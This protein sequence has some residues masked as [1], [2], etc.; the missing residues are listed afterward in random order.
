[1]PDPYRRGMLLIARATS[2]AERAWLH[3]MLDTTAD[4]DHTD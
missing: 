1:M 4:Q 3:D 2:G